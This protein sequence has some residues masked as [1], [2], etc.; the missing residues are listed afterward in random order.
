MSRLLDQINTLGSE[1]I[2]RAYELGLA[3]S[4]KVAAKLREERDYFMCKHDAYVEEVSA[5]QKELGDCERALIDS[6]AANDLLQTEIDTL[7][8][9][10]NEDDATI[11]DL[12][13]QLNSGV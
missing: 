4:A 7:M 5:L 2:R 8:M 1:A 13:N 6:Q 3:D 10:Q 11:T 9:G 12:R